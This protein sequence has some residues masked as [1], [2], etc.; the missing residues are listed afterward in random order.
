MLGAKIGARGEI[1]TVSNITPELLTIKDEAF[2][3]DMASIGPARVNHEMLMIAQITIGNRTFIGNAALAPVGADIP[4]GCLIGV[5][6]T[7]P[8]GTIEPKSTWLGLPPIYLPRR[9]IVEGFMENQTYKPGLNAYALRYVYEF[10]RVTLP[11]AFAYGIFGTTLLF[12]ME[13]LVILGPGLLLPLL[14]FIYLAPALIATLLV[15]ALKWLFIGRYRPRIEPLWSHFVR[16]TEFITA[17]YENI[18]VPLIIGPLLGTPFHVW[19]C[20]NSA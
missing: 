12:S 14:P 2:I 13:D 9:Q 1:S 16:R 8:K 20:A 10:F 3:A 18:A 11:P 7:P 19:C 17:L 4:D 6:S 5:Q 15:V